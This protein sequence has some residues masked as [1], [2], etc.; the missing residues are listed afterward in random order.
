LASGLFASGETKVIAH[1]AHWA[2]NPD[3]ESKFARAVGRIPDVSDSQL[4]AMLLE[5]NYNG[6][7]Y[8]DAVGI[9]GHCFF[10]LHDNELHA[11]AAWIAERRRG[12][13]LMQV[14]FFD[15]LA[16]ASTQPGVARVRIGTGRIADRL[17]APLQIVSHRLGW[18]LGGD[19]WV[20]L[21]NQSRAMAA[22]SNCLPGPNVE[23]GSDQS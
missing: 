15:L 5:K 12:R 8:A 9:V 23:P 22:T 13:A 20:D 7:L 11:F 18:R 21:P 1:I 14:S 10:Q 3:P 4:V 2:R 19:G 17:L 16:Y 6:L